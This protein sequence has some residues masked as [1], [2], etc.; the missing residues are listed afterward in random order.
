[1][2]TNSF[3]SGKPENAWLERAIGGKTTAGDRPGPSLACAE[4]S[5]GEPMFARQ[6]GGAMPAIAPNSDGDN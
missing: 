4:Q 3:A 6:E 1:M 2:D 5:I